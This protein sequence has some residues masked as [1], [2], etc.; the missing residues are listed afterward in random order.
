M[1]KSKKP[2]HSHPIRGWS[3]TESRECLG[4]GVSASEQAKGCAG[5]NPHFFLRN[6]RMHFSQVLGTANDGGSFTT[7]VCLP[8]TAV[9]T[10]RRVLGPPGRAFLSALRDLAARCQRTLSRHQTDRA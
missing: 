6:R 10:S 7:P 8:P 5:V 1:T 3:K 2:Q 9:P 4:V